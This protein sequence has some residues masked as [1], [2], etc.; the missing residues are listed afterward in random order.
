MNV[1]DWILAAAAGFSVLRG[2]MRGAV[3]QIFGIAGILAG[4]FVAAHNYEQVGAEIHRNF[5]SFAGT[6]TIA[7]ILLFLLTWFCIAVVGY[8]I[9]RFMRSAGLGFLDRLW[10]GMIGFG[11]AVILA[12]AAV[13]VLTMFAAQDSPLL[14]HS[15]LVPYVKEASRFLFKIAPDRVQEEFSRKQKDLERFL[16]GSTTLSADPASGPQRADKAKSEKRRE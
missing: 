10:G 16:K 15:V 1:L 2:L 11:K 7:F 3:S 4:F 12:I 5:P 6:G 14:T 13:A 8:W 9:G